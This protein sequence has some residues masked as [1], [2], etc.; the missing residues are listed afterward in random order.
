[1]KEAAVQRRHNLYRDSIVLTNSDPNLHLLGESPQVDWAA[2]FGNN[3]PDGTVQ[4]RA[5]TEGGGSGSRRRQVVSMIQLDGL[6][7]AYESC[8]EVPGVDVIPEEDSK[9]TEETPEEHSEDEDTDQ[10]PMSPDSVDEIRDLI[11]PVVE[12][13][14]PVSEEEK[15]RKTN[16]TQPTKGKLITED[17]VQEDVT[18]ITTVVDGAP[19]KSFRDKKS[20]QTDIQKLLGN[21]EQEGTVENQEEDDA[22][23]KTQPEVQED[24]SATTVEIPVAESGSES[25]QVPTDSSSREDSGF[26]SPSNLESDDSVPQPITNGLNGE[27]KVIDPA[28]VEVLLA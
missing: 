14:L 21:G 12:V 10:V 28:E 23:D 8:L 16:V 20:P 13:A 25:P 1:M 11:N 19:K 17:G 9:T 3:E 22:K 2:K 15:I 18:H 26:Q 5:S 7:V 24:E 4:E 27:D 6:P